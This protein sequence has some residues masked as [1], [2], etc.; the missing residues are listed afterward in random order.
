MIRAIFLA[1]LLLL[2]LVG[3]ILLYRLSMRKIEARKELEE[4]K[5]EHEERKELFDDEDL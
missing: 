4:R 1:G 3:V 2:G 5:M